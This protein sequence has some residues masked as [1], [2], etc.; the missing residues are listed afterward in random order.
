VD[1]VDADIEGWLWHFA[2]PLP[3]DCRGAFYVAAES[4]L[5]SVSCLGPGVAYRTLAELL[6]SYFIPIPDDDRGNHG[7]RQCRRPSKLTL[8]APLGRDR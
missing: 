6:T 1:T 5:A 2:A 3:P 8:A 4:A 7:A